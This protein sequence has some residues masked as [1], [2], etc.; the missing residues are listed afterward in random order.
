MRKLI[1]VVMWCLIQEIVSKAVTTEFPTVTTESSVATTESLAGTSKGLTTETTSLQLDTDTGSG[2]TENI[3]DD[4]G[5]GSG[6]GEEKDGSGSGS[7]QEKDGSGSN[8]DQKEDGSGSNIDQEEDDSGSNID[9]EENGSGSDG[10]Q[11]SNI[12]FTTVM[13]FENMNFTQS[14][15]NKSSQDYV[16]LY[17]N[18][19]ES[20]IQATGN[21]KTEVENSIVEILFKEGSIKAEIV[22]KNDDD[23]LNIKNVTEKRLAE[24]GIQ[25][26]DIEGKVHIAE[27]LS[28]AVTTAAPTAVPTEPPTLLTTSTEKSTSDLSGGGVAGIVIGCVVLVSITVY[29]ILQSRHGKEHKIKSLEFDRRLGKKEAW[30]D[31][32]HPP[33]PQIEVRGLASFASITSF[34]GIDTMQRS[35]NYRVVDSPNGDPAK[36]SVERIHYNMV[37][38]TSP[39]QPDLPGSPSFDGK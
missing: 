2:S 7:D 1:F 27:P 39:S 5:S 11:E 25:V 4:L 24:G 12:M 15:R 36:Y 26:K 14:L 38:K 31:N 17:D 13:Y 6:S 29:V 37:Q 3:S 8:I 35:P 33:E 16:T 9:Q 19:I 32:S 23:A 10:E 34:H 21:N 20:L 28:T 18:T 30:R 22:W